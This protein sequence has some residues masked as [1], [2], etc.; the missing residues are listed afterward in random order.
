MNH[1]KSKNRFTCTSGWYKMNF[2]EVKTESI[3]QF[4]V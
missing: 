4:K 3:N 1:Y 2:R